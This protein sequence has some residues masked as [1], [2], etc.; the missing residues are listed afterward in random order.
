MWVYDFPEM[1]KVNLCRN[2][3]LVSHCITLFEA[4]NENGEK[5]KA[6]LLFNVSTKR[7][8]GLEY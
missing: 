4:I 8:T 6:V 3:V 2:S 7:L 1:I 5:V